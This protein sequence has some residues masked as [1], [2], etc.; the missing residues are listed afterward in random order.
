M[1]DINQFE[2]EIVEV[3]VSEILEAESR[4]ADTIVVITCVAAT[5]CLESTSNW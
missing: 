1:Q 5:V 2:N 3:A 4:N